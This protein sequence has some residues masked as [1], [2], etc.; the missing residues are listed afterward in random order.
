M[1]VGFKNGFSI[2]KRFSIRK[3]I[4]NPRKDFRSKIEKNGFSIQQCIFSPKMA[5][6]VKNWIFN[7]IIGLKVAKK[8][9]KCILGAN[10]QSLRGY[11][12]HFEIKLTYES[13]IENQ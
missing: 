13:L 2:Q 7:P 9:N 3:W 12:I 8:P 1:D 4:F 10:V 11:S 5:F 6:S